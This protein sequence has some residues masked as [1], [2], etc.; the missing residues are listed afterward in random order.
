MGAFVAKLRV[1]HH[2]FNQVSRY[3]ERMLESKELVVPHGEAGLRAKTL[4]AWVRHLYDLPW[5]KA[6]ELCARGKVTVNGEVCMDAAARVSP[7]SRVCVEP[8]GQ[9]RR[10]QELSDDA[11]V[12]LDND[13]VVVFKPAGLMTVPFDDA[14]EDT[15]AE[16]VRMYLKRR[17]GRGQELGVVQRL[18]KDTTGIMVFARTLAAKRHLQQQFRVHS[19]ER[20]YLAVV[21]GDCPA[22]QCDSHFIRNR[23]D[24][25]RGSYGH[26][27]KPKGPLP[28]DAQHA[29]TTVSPEE[30]LRDATLVRCRLHSGRQHQIRIHLSEMG[31]P[32]VGESVYIRDYTG[33]HIA[34]PRPMLHATLLHFDHPR[35]GQRMTFEAPPP[36]DFMALTS[37][38]AR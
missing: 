1:R 31:H 17:K 35:S 4:A 29:I 21:H 36:R 6:R 15:L 24:G 19:I 9:R 7:G 20:Q 16:R 14:H 11:L 22:A 25:L 18:D 37:V 12:Y 33:P 13:V 8:Q 23:G 38:L 5:S 26:F 27:R 34:A 28:E 10:P 32:L 3:A 2:L 30:R